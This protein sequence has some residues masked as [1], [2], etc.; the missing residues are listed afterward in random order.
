MTHTQPIPIKAVLFDLGGVLIRTEDRR[1]RTMLADAFGMTYAELEKIV[2]GGPSGDAAQQGI[3][4]AAQH[5]ENVRVALHM[6]EDEVDAVKT[7]FFGGDALDR[8][9]LN[10]IRSLRPRYTV[11]ALSNA[12]SDTRASLL[13]KWQLGDAFDHFFISAEMGMMKPDP[14]IYQTVL[15]HLGLAPA[16]T[17]FVDD[18]IQNIQGAQSVGMRAVWF[19]GREQA[20]E[21]L[22]K[23]LE[24]G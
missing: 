15:H 4:S 13:N 12:M 6:Q 18:F 17:V 20:L 11:A 2:F 1:P 16:E 3:I 5:W 23:I 9:L 10:Y 19:R 14:R 21:D 22:E 8:E 24:N 7:A